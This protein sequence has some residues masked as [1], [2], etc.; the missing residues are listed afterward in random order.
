M[1]GLEKNISW[2]TE[3]TYSDPYYSN[4]EHMVYKADSNNLKLFGVNWGWAGDIKPNN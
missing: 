3:C 1:Y 2:I 4:V